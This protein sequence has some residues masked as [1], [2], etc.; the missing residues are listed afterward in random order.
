MNPV[1]CPVCGAETK[2]GGLCAA[3]ALADAFGTDDAA[4]AKAGSLGV[5]GGHELIEIIARGGMGIVYRARQHE[6]ERE[7]ALKA[8]PGAELRSEEARQRFRIEGHAMARLEHPHILPVHEI[9][10]EDGTPFYTMKLADG[11]TLAE[12][13]ASYAGAWREIA[14]LSATLAEA[15][16]FAHSR[17]VLHRDLK[18]GNILFD[19]NDTVYVSDFGLAKLVGTDTDLTRTI[20]MM[21]TPAYLAPELVNGGK[22]GASAA[23]DVWSL[24]VMLYELL[25]GQPPFR[26]ENAAAL[27]RQIAEQEP[28]ALNGT[29]VGQAPR[30]PEPTP[31]AGAAALQSRIPRDLAVITFKAL[32]KEPAR[33]YRTAQ[34]LADDLRRW[35]AGEPIHARPVPLAERAW[36]WA[37]RKPAL[38]A[39]LALLALTLIGSAALLVRSNEHLRS[40]E[41]RL[42]DTDK[43]RRGEIHRALLEKADAER[44]SKFPGRRERA[45]ALVREALT[46]GPSAQARSVAASALAVSDARVTQT[47]PV[48]RLVVGLSPMHFTPD[49]S[50]HVALVPAAQ[51]R[52]PAWKEGALGLWRTADHALL[53]Q[54]PLTDRDSVGNPTLSPDRRWLS[55]SQSRRR[56]EI[57]DLENEQRVKVLESKLLPAALFHPTDG[58]LIVLLNGELARIHLPEMRIETLASGLDSGGRLAISP[59]GKL[60]AFPQFSGRDSLDLATSTQVRSLLDG[61]LVCS[62]DN[63]PWGDIKWTSDSRHIAAFDRNNGIL[64]LHEITAG[65][66]PPPREVARS[67]NTGRRVAVWPD[68]RTLGWTDNAGF[69]HLEDLWLGEE[70]LLIPATASALAPGAD[71]AKFA[72]TPDST[73]AAL[74][75]LLPSPILLERKAVPAERTVDAELAAS[76]DGRWIATAHHFGITLWRAAD[77]TPVAQRLTHQPYETSENLHFSADSRQLRFHVKTTLRTVWDIVETDAGV[78]LEG[79]GAGSPRADY[80]LNA[81]S[82][83][84]RWECTTKT[85]EKT[86]H[87]HLWRD[88]EVVGKFKRD[89]NPYRVDWTSRL[90]SPDGRWAAFGCMAQEQ[91]EKPGFTYVIHF[92]G[93]NHRTI[94]SWQASHTHL[95]ISPDSRWLIGGESADYVIWTSTTWKSAFRLPAALSD[96]VPGSAAFSPD[97]TLLALEVDHGRIRLLRLGSWEE[98]LTITPP[99]N[100]PLVRMAFS[101]DG[102]HLYTT[103]EQIL[104]RWDM[105]RLRDELEKM[106]IAW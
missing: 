10:E 8:L 103:G 64:A 66:A 67:T 25:A 5:I 42:R 65:K 19:G 77:L 71:G 44:Q 1:H 97:G 49:L 93:D 9:G 38:A 36:L 32:A 80:M 48:G 31:A 72:F 100:I 81:A 23:S 20:A 43:Q 98:V 85:G 24:G 84:G 96:S 13:I 95:A 61:S 53:K 73:T 92:D 15:V 75:E 87:F 59:D 57:W 68:G 33:R 76:P 55:F 91:A 46:Y 34:E 41:Q 16:Q 6:P 101:P 28:E 45:L 39:A 58:S 40:S 21:G 89:F 12:R 18:P 51:V 30:L 69:L 35:L 50:H 47:W 52:E 102:R 94:L 83:S 2:A 54:I 78:K 106:G 60:V 56:L 90:L 26:A 105:S 86:S 88:G 62:I 74:G 17:G 3:C 27:L 99:Q 79:A 29:T 37:K 22:D 4:E 70:T 7:V 82:V 11:G 63:R 104:H 14:E